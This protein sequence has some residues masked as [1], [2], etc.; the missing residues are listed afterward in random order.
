MPRAALE[1]TDVDHVLPLR[2]IA[3]FLNNLIGPSHA[4][5]D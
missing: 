1:S 3:P 5:T 4:N 2:D